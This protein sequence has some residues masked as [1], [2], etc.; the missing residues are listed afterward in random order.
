[1]KLNEE[2]LDHLLEGCKTPGDVDTLYSQ[3]LQRIINRSLDAEM[4]AHLEEG[5]AQ[6]RINRRN[7]KMSKVVKGTF[8][9]LPI[10]TPRDRQGDFE[11]QL[12]KKRQI[13]LGGMEEK[14][15]ALYA[16]GMTTRDIESA[17]VDLYGVN[18]SHSVIAQVTDAVLDEVHA[19]QN[20]PLETIYPIVWMDGIVVKVRQGKQVINKAVHVV[21]AVNLHGEKEVLGLWITEHEGSKYWLSVLTELKNRGVQDIYIACMD[22]LKGLSEAV[23][24]VFPQTLTQLCIVHLVRASLRYVTHK[25]SKAVVAALKGIYQS[26]TIE[27]AEQALGA[28]EEAWGNQYRAVIRLWKENWDNIVPFFQFPPELRKIVYTTNAIES[29]NAS[30]RKLTRNR[31]IFPNDDS[32]YKAMYLAIRHCADKWKTIHHWKPALQ[33]FQIVFGED[34]VPVREL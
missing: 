28:L 17:L 10:E 32:V 30:L 14:I 21:L 24:A 16:R 1:M 15:L 23:N 9:E 19:W 11:P 3:L 12:V 20:R 4:D 25:D 2:Q 33:V 13:R 8:G 26:A 34:R 5:K 6:G 29:L 27:G 7:G 31:R 22:G 18:V